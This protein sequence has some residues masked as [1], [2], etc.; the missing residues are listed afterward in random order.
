MFMLA[1]MMLP[2]S[3]SLIPNYMIMAKIGW[4]NTWLPL[5]I[6]GLATPFSVFWMR[7]YITS[8]PDEMV[9][10]AQIDGCGPFGIYWRVIVPVIAPGLAA[11][12]IFNF[13]GNWNSFMAPL[14]YL[15]NARIYPVPLFLALLNTSINAQ[16]TPYTL[17]FAA[18]LISLLPILAVF[19]G[20]QRYFIAGLTAGSLK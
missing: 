18:A 3:V 6:P 14:I 5:I 16:P 7:Q 15:N 17:T 13:M 11:L 2:G 19:L 1:T 4:I 10:A 9:E 8:V 20:A 12:T